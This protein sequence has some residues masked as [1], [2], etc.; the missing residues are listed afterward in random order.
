MPRRLLCIASV[1]LGAVLTVHGLVGLYRA[2]T[3]TAASRVGL[4]LS[5]GS[6]MVIVGGVYLKRKSPN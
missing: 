6:L 1:L 5:L 3:T 2:Q 4:E